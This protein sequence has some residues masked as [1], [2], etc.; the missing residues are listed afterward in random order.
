LPSTTTAPCPK[1][2]SWG[3]G[4]LCQ[5]LVLAAQLLVQPLDLP[6]ILLVP[7]L[8]V[9]LVGH[10]HHNHEYVGW[11]PTLRVLLASRDDVTL[12]VPDLAALVEGDHVDP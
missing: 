7:L 4:P 3:C 2:S 6:L 1:H 11:S 12:Q 9:L 8:E 10:L 5:G